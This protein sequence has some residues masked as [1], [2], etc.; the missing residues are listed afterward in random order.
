[1][2]HTLPVDRSV[3][4]LQFSRLS[5]KYKHQQYL[6]KTMKPMKLCVFGGQFGSEGKGSVA[7]ILIKRRNPEPGVK[8]IVAGENSPNSGHTNSVGKTRNIPVSSFFTNAVLMGPD[9]VISPKCLIEDLKAVA[10][11]KEKIGAD[12]P[13]QVYLHEN[14]AY[15]HESDH[16]MEKTV[17]A[18]VSSTGSGSGWSRVSKCFHR[19]P[20]ATVG[21][22][23]GFI[24]ELEAAGIFNVCL[25]NSNQYLAFIESASQH[26]WLFECSQGALLDVNFGYF[27]Y[28]TSRTTLPRVAIE[29]NGLGGMGIWEYVG[30]YRTFPIRTGGPS[31]PTGGSECQFADLDVPAEIATVTGR[32]RRI[33]RFSS[34]DFIRS[35]TLNRPDLIAF[36]HL[37]YIKMKDTELNR[38]M[39]WLMLDGQTE[40][41]TKGCSWLLSHQTGKGVVYE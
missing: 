40:R 28:V 25:M 17:V 15:C 3:Q 7:E 18:R 36:T 8:L 6:D 19:D 41:L 31:G 13:F 22:K 34:E 9:S 32:T 37:D 5:V 27:P 2:S 24:A 29:R 33:F 23:V 10:A 20:D 39:G 38:F 26:D 1:M 14:A 4:P 12:G 30:V 11:Y 35:L 21:S 16:L